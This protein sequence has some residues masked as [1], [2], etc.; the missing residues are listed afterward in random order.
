MATTNAPLDGLELLSEAAV[1]PEQLFGGTRLHA[2]HIGE[3][4]LRL[5]ILQDAIRCL[6][7]ES[8]FSCARRD[9]REAARWIAADDASWPFSFVNVCEALDM[10]AGR[11]RR[12]LLHP[13]RTIRRVPRR[14]SSTRSR[15]E[16][17][18]RGE[19][20]A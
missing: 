1:L 9:R 19:V 17:P 15:V 16:G 11:L 5:A 10:D 7:A 2:G 6:A 4:A 14:A 13:P 8:E 20:A 3:L 18:D 12:V